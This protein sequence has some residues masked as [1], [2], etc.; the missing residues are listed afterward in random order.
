MRLPPNQ[1]DANAG[2]G[3]G[4]GGDD[5]GPP[6]DVFCADSDEHRALVKATVSVARLNT[7]SKRMYESGPAR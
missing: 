4:Q 1:D 2:F 3:D 5:G 6:L 7:D